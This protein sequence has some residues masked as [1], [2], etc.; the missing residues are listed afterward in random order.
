M[1][2][3]N[4]TMGR[5]QL[6]VAYSEV[7]HW[8]SWNCLVRRADQLLGSLGGTT[9]LAAQQGVQEAVENAVGA[10]IRAKYPLG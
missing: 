7:E 5:L 9:I 3:F 10:A 4:A 2:Q 6:E 8:I 1:A